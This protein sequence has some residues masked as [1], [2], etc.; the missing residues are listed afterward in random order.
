MLEVSRQ[1]VASETIISSESFSHVLL[2]FA[3]FALIFQTNRRKPA[4]RVSTQAVKIAIAKPQSR[5]ST[6]D[7]K[8]PDR[9]GRNGCAIIP[10]KSR[11]ARFKFIP[12][13]GKT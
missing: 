12:R 8:S 13:T 10:P 5:S 9:F 11:L 7:L 3:A 1:D 6:T 2:S 4:S